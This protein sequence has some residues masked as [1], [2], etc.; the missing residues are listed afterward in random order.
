[1]SSREAGAEW[2]KVRACWVNRRLV[3][4]YHD[5]YALLEIDPPAPNTG[6]RN[7]IVA[8]HSAGQ[9][10]FPPS[11]VPLPVYVYTLKRKPPGVDKPLASDDVEL[12]AWCE[13]YASREDATRVAAML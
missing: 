5:Q 7:V 2:T 6:D 4:P 10:L 3:G 12:V 1:M 8:P 11:E 13:L 9:L